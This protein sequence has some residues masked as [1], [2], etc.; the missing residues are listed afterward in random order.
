MNNDKKQ[1]KSQEKSRA[2]LERKLKRKTKSLRK[3]RSLI[4]IGLLIFAIALILSFYMDKNG[5]GEGDGNKVAVTS[6]NAEENLPSNDTN[7]E[8]ELANIL[9]EIIIDSHDVIY[10]EEIVTLDRL[11]TILEAEA[12]TEVIL[13][14]QVAY[15]STYNE[16]AELLDV[17]GITYSETVRNQ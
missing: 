2:K 12:V 6:K 5:I 14:D 10:N 11:K 15:I 8:D 3:T 9:P 17:L 13:V 4:L 7:T 1:I 16:V